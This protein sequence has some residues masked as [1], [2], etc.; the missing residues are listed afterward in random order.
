[1]RKAAIHADA[2]MLYSIILHNVKLALRTLRKAAIHAD[3]S[4]LYSI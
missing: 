1:L 4:M 3:A 2:S